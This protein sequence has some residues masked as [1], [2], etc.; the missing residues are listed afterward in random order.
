MRWCRVRW[1]TRFTST[2]V[3]L[4]SFDTASTKSFLVNVIGGAILAYRNPP[5]NLMYSSSRLVTLGLSSMTPLRDELLRREIPQGLMG[6]NRVVD[7]FPPL[8]GLVE[9]P[10]GRLDRADL[11]ELLAVRA[12]GP[13]DAPVELRRPRGQHEE[14][15]PPLLAG[16]LEGRLELAAP[17]DLQRL[18]AEG[19]PGLA[20]VEEAGRQGGRELRVGVHDVPAR[21]DVARREVRQAQPRQWAQVQ[22]IDL[23]QI[24]GGPHDVVLRLAD[25]VGPGQPAPR[26]EAHT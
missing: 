1:T 2:W 5:V 8:Q 3:M 17:I 22:R 16:G 12:L 9:G 23:E 19:H 4:V 18:D 21:D 24:A 25:G 26:S 20:G 7:P 13:L 6:P 11:V 15:Q 10:D 14:A